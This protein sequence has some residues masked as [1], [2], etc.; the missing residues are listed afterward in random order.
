MGEKG[1]SARAVFVVDKQGRLAYKE[2]SRDPGD[3]SQIPSNARVLDALQAL[4]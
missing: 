1:F 3:M 4:S 2:V